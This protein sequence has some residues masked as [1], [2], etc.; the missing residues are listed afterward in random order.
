MNGSQPKGKLTGLQGKGWETQIRM[1]FHCENS[2][3]GILY[4]LGT[5]GAIYLV[6]KEATIW[7]V[8]QEKSPTKS[9]VLWS[10]SSAAWM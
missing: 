6:G 8:A 7:D 4:M 1:D 3:T 9:Q 5:S 2:L 10:K